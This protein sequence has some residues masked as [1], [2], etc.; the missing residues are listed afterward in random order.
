[1]NDYSIA[2]KTLPLCYGRTCYCTYGGTLEYCSFFGDAQLPMGLVQIGCHI[3]PAFEV[4]CFT[5]A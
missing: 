1:M 2:E 5:N 3:S 4:H